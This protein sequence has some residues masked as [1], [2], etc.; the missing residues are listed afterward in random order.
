MSYQMYKGLWRRDG[1]IATGGQHLDFN[2]TTI[3]DRL[4]D[5][6]TKEQVDAFIAG[7]NPDLSAYATIADPTFTTAINIQAGSVVATL[8]ADG[9]NSHLVIGGITVLEVVA[10]LL[11]S[12]DATISGGIVT[13]ND[14]YGGQITLG[15]VLS[16]LRLVGVG[17]DTIETVSSGNSY[18]NL[19]TGA[20]TAHGDVAITGG[21]SVGLVSGLTASGVVTLLTNNT[22]N[23]G[24]WSW[25]VGTSHLDS[26]AFTIKNVTGSSTALSFAYA[27]NNATFSGTV[28][29]SNLSGTNTGD[30]TAHSLGLGTGDSPTFAG[31]TISGSGRIYATEIYKNGTNLSFRRAS[32]DFPLGYFNDDLLNLGVPLK[33]SDVRLRRGATNAFFIDNG[34]DL[35][36]ARL[37][38]GTITDTGETLIVGGDARVN[39]PITVSSVNLNAGANSLGIDLQGSSN[40]RIVS[41]GSFGGAFAPLDV[42][43]TSL[44]LSG[45][46]GLPDIDTSTTA[47]TAAG[48]TCWD[49]VAGRFQGYDSAW[50]AFAR[51]GDSPTFAS[52]TCTGYTTWTNDT[53]INFYVDHNNYLGNV[54]N[55]YT[56]GHVRA[57][58]D[59]LT[60]NGTFSGDLEVSDNTKGLILKSPDG[61]RWR[62]SVSNSGVISATSI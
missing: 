2:F 50:K 18:A 19:I 38:V 46:L 49:S 41:T 40:H 21:L 11:V 1:S 53:I 58:I 51:D 48:Q 54:T 23:G 20:I 31:V 35:G 10:D 14:A 52:T 30:Q 3:A 29:A 45:F 60:G 56:T 17:T 34:T 59:G 28:T 4:A 42:L 13:V 33:M 27:T 37:A 39:G 6:Y 25:S 7:I 5:S 12:G 36:A 44:N 57:S 47:G 24:S 15:N 26:Y 22:S 16:K 62:I 8:T 61:T 9:G 32:D 43:A 55:F